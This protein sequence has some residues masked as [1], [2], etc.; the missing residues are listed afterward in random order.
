VLPSGTVVP[1]RVATT[2]ADG[3]LRLPTDVRRA[4]W[5]D[6][7]AR[8]GDALGSI[9]VAA[10][11]DSFDQGLG[12]FAQLLSIHR[13]DD[14]M[15]RSGGL[16]QRFEVTSARLVPKTSLTSTSPLYTAQTPS[17]LVLIT[18]GGSFE[19]AKGGYQDNFVVVAEPRG[20]LRR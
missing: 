8:L 10:H 18:C 3:A 12:V 17:R 9:V 5:W 13:G 19:P 15:V 7:S 4:G 16:S 2:G 1:V 11:V 6:G 20:D 14:V